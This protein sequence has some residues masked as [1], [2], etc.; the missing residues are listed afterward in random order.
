MAIANDIT[1]ALAR[2]QTLVDEW[3]QLARS[4]DWAPGQQIG[5]YLLKQR[6]GKGGMGVVWLAD[7]LQPLQREV[8][9]K[10]MAGE[11]RDAWAETWFEIERQALAQLSHRGIAQIF[12]AGR[13]P[14][15][16][17]FFAMEY[18][19]GVPLDEFQQAHPLDPRALAALFLQICAAVQHAHQ[20]GLIHRDLKPL[21]V[22]VQ[23]LDGEPVAKII[24]FGIAVRALPG[25]ATP[26][27]VDRVVG[28]P[29]YM[30]PEQ[31]Q[32]GPGGI[33][34]RC[35]IYALGVMLGESLCRAGGPPADRE[36]IDVTAVHDAVR[37]ELGQ[38]AYE[39]SVAADALRP[40]LKRAPRELLAI[41]AKAMSADREQR[42]ESAAAMTDD[43]GRWLARR[44]VQAV[45]GGRVYAFRCLIRRNRIASLAATLVL[46][47]IL[48]GSAL[49]WAGMR[50]AQRAQALAEQRRDD[51]EKLIQFMLGDFADKLRP[52]GR[53][54]L[55]DGI[56]SEALKYLS[57]AN[58]GADA[59]SALARARALR[60]L[61]EVQATRQQFGVAGDTLTQAN[62]MLASFADG[63]GPERAEIS[64]ELG[65]IAFYRGLVEFR[66]KRYAQA[67]P[68]WQAYLRHALAYAPI[69]PDPLK[70][71]LE[72]AYA[73]NNL[74]ALAEA[75][76][77]FEDALGH[78][79]RAAALYQ[80]FGSA[81]GDAFTLSHAN[82][83]SWIA[84]A[85]AELG[86]P[87]RALRQ[88][89]AA[90][91]LI[92]A[93]GHANPE[94]AQQ[95]QREIN[96]RLA[97]A[98]LLVDIGQGAEARTQLRTAL[99]LAQ[100]DVANDPSQPRRQAMLARIGYTL[101]RLEAPRGPAALAAI[102]IADRGLAALSDDALPKADHLGLSAG[103]C[104]ARAHAQGGS[105]CVP[106]M[107]ERVLDAVDPA[108]PEFRLV[109]RAVELLVLLATSD[110]AAATRQ[111]ATVAALLRA[112]EPRHGVKLRY[113][114]LSRMLAAIP[115]TEA[116]RLADLDAR[117]EALLH[118][119]ENDEIP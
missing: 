57:D 50:E 55:L 27:R 84:N 8:A 68:H 81:P 59:D 74:G 13:L 14:D 21:N 48:G 86:R 41:A 23:R 119:E 24:D 102:E 7:Q 100:A 6:L 37:L 112:L 69:A 115:P 30:S 19:P 95:R 58:A 12:D 98:Q 61:G 42:Y 45:G 90:L 62:A 16:A 32:P 118:P 111:R 108:D 40:R 93:Y 70:G 26:F 75:E 72:I 104:V 63:E 64:F 117:I 25:V 83:L 56:G 4:D 85:E 39:R 88:R 9:I 67:L 109:D 35:D 79:E 38:N 54:D 31:K 52:I 51:A 89:S 33:D 110:P 101:A 5:P 116:A 17:L 53:L 80:G 106:P 76:T 113:L 46:A 105:A 77:R 94:E 66:Q 91:D 60:T 36:S 73:E 65:Q 49:A 87:L 43:L 18:V 11:R 3:P 28:T 44:P 97:H 2:P 1:S 22:L 96:A 103:G 20:R 47:A 99:E 82:T 107:L 92:L 34:A 71:R 78:F 29:A 114:T 10:V 15:G